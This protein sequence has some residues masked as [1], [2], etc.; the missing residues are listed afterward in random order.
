MLT[1][2]GVQAARM[3]AWSSRTENLETGLVLRLKGGEMKVPCLHY[4][5]PQGSVCCGGGDPR[6]LHFL[7]DVL[8]FA[9]ESL[10]FPL[11]TPTFLFF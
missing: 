10:L 1:V 7:S 6:G 9:L 8:I 11:E 4:H 2:H 5:G 3:K